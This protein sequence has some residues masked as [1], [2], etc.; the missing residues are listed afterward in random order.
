MK[1][2]NI[3]LLSMVLSVSFAKIYCSI[4]QL[5]PEQTEEALEALKIAEA[6]KLAKAFKPAETLKPELRIDIAGNK[7]K[8]VIDY[9]QTNLKVKDQDFINAKD[10]ETGQ[11]ALEMAVEAGQKEIANALLRFNPDLKK[12]LLYAAQENNVEMIKLLLKQLATIKNEI[13]RGKIIDEYDDQGQNALMLTKS[14]EIAGLLIDAGIDLDHRDIKNKTALEIMIKKATS[15]KNSPHEIKNYKEI[16]SSI[17]A[18]LKMPIIVK[19]EGETLIDNNDIEGFRAYIKNLDKTDS[20]KN[21]L[22]LKATKENKPQFAFELI[23]SGAQVNIANENGF[24]PLMF[25][26]SNGNLPLVMSLV[27][28]GAKIDLDEK[29]FE[30][31]PAYKLI[32]ELNK[33]DT[34]HQNYL[35]IL[36]YFD[37]LR[38]QA[39]KKQSSQ[40]K[41]QQG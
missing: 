18:A 10:P 26:V 28:H 40:K 35:F 32:V 2:N 9:F 19:N 37:L 7:L 13:Q 24:T 16:I 17:E 6:F 38:D 27:D 20:K 1:R 4:E 39:Q 14:P 22:M 12:A 30:D 33:R 15:T 5:E 41:A 23:K 29:R 11:T 21:P 31:D 8:N 34:I 3:L 36:R 25:A